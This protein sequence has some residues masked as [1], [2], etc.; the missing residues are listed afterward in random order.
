M[1][2]VLATLLAGGLEILIVWVAANL[3]GPIADARTPLQYIPTSL[4]VTC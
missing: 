2:G 3:L 4:I 1:L